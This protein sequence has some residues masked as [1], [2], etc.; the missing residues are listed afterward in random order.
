MAACG[1][2][3][4]PPGGAN[5]DAHV[6]TTPDAPPGAID[7]PG[8]IGPPANI[9]IYSGDGLMAMEQW[10][11]GDQMKVLVT[12]ASHRS[13]AG[14]DVTWQ[15]TSGF[16]GVTGNF[17]TGLTGTSTTD[18]NGLARVGIRG[19]AESQTTSS[20]PSTIHASI[21][22]GGVDF[23]AFSTYYT[24]QLPEMPPMYIT[25]P[26][27]RDLGTFTPG[28][29]VTGAIIANV[30]FS[31]GDQSG[32]GAPGVGVRIISSSGSTQDDTPPIAS[33]A[34]ATVGVAAGGTVYTDASGNA[35]CDLRVPTTPGDYAIG[36]FVAGATSF[37]P[38][39][40]HVQ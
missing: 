4:R 10:P 31:Q 22:A 13:V 28:A 39:L 40:V 11:G 7:A 34:N 9:E 35:T 8:A 15:V 30:S 29:V 37:S 6:A 17:V 36:I 32:R 25:T 24:L 19:E 27:G 18:A 14:V 23:H 1:T 3:T 26:Q 38:F 12:D 33:C 2:S 21:A 5:I 20:W 16:V